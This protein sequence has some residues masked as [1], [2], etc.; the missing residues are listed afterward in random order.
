MSLKE[1]E[2]DFEKL[3]Q[4]QNL[5]KGN[6]PNIDNCHEALCILLEMVVERCAEDLAIERGG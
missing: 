6:V 1:I 3:K 4:A 2:D 5:L